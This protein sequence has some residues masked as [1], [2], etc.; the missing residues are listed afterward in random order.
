MVLCSAAMFLWLFL[1]VKF[2]TVYHNFM[3]E[4]SWSFCLVMKRCFPCWF[5]WCLE[6]VPTFF[7]RKNIRSKELSWP[8]IGQV[9]QRI[10]ERSCISLIIIRVTL[11]MISYLKPPIRNM[12]L[13]RY[14]QTFPGF[15][16]CVCL[17]VPC[18]FIV[19][20]CLFSPKLLA[21]VSGRTNS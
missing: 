14:F 5:G 16:F 2:F 17:L 8:L 3:K 21:R 12:F 13:F 4:K 9:N 19:D 10:G 6:Q 18:S 1:K 20:N 15:F 11:E 7:S